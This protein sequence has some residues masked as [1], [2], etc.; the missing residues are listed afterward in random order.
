[1]IR[2]ETL[3]TRDRVIQHDAP[4]AGQALHLTRRRKFQDVKEAVKKE[5]GEKRPGRD[6]HSD[7]REREGKVFVRDDAAVIL[8]AEMPFGHAADGNGRQDHGDGQKGVTEDAGF[9]GGPGERQAGQGAHRAGH[10]SG[11]AG[12]KPRGDR[13]PQALQS[14]KKRGLHG[15][16]HSGLRRRR[17]GKGVR[18]GIVLAGAVYGVR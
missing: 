4:A 3:Q 16:Q 10:P 17:N 18:R 12:P 6:R 1:M 8:A 5:G 13:Q 7:H 9:G 14:G 15:L 11:A 2:R